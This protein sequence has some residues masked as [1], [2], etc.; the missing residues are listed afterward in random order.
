MLKPVSKDQDLVRAMKLFKS[1]QKLFN[2][3]YIQYNTVISLHCTCHLFLFVF[4][5]LLDQCK[6]NPL[7]VGTSDQ[8]QLILVTCDILQNI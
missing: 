8:V 5:I 2:K 6:Y 3:I 4:P 1:I 7:L